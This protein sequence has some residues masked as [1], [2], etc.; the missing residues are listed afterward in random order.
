MVRAPQLCTVSGE[1]VRK[2]EKKEADVCRE[3]GRPKVQKETTR[4]FNKGHHYRNIAIIVV[5]NSIQEKHLGWVVT[6]GIMPG[7]P[8][9]HAYRR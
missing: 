4:Y 7:I 5:C 6:V 8:A 1:G 9:V 2:A 3:G